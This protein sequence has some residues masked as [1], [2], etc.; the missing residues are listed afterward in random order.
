MNGGLYYVGHDALQAS[1]KVVEVFIRLSAHKL[2]RNMQAHR[3]PNQT[4]P[5]DQVRFR[6]ETL[7]LVQD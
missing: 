5:K 7:P 4:E 6:S 3:R 2:T 1:L